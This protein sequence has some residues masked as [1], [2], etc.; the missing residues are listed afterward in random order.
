[1]TEKSKEI[2]KV[3]LV[4]QESKLDAL[5]LCKLFMSTKKI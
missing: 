2:Q 5:F 4:L 3:Y 1:M